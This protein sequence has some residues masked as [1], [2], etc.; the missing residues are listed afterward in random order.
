VVIVVGLAVVLTTAA[1]LLHGL[2][3]PRMRQQHA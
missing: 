1:D 2:L 3:N